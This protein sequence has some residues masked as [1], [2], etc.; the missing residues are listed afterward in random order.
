MDDNFSNSEKSPNEKVIARK[1][2]DRSTTKIERKTRVT[3]NIFT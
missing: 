3:G 1:G 2:W